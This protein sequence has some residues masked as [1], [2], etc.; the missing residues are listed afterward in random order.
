ML[1]QAAP[2][3]RLLPTG[4]LRSRQWNLPIL[5]PLSQ[6]DQALAGFEELAMPLFD[7][8][9]NFARWLVHNSND[10]EDLV[11]ESYLKALRSFASFQPGTNFRAWIFQILRNTFLSSRSKLDRR[12]TVAMASEENGPELAVDTETPETILMN[13]SN[14]QLVQRAISDLPLHYR[15]TLL[16]CEVEEMSYQQIADILSIPT[17]TVMSRLARARKAVRESLLSAPACVVPHR[18]V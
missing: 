1:K 17:G 2:R 13:R 9:Y 16:L 11:Q 14:S 7:S 15:E 6:D 3:G 10:A 8:L 12:M 5:E 4:S 18:C